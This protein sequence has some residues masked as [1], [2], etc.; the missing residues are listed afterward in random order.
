MSNVVKWLTKAV[1]LKWVLDY[2]TTDVYYSFIHHSSGFSF[3]M[4]LHD[5]YR[6]ELAGSALWISSQQAMSIKGNV[7]IVMTI[8]AVSKLARLLNYPLERLPPDFSY[9]IEINKIKKSSLLKTQHLFQL[10]SMRV[11][12][13]WIKSQS[14]LFKRQIYLLYNVTFL[15]VLLFTKSLRKA[16]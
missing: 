3:C 16:D 5:Q 9:F 2:L 8:M 13:N 4:N 11:A 14:R 10:S 12:G 1:Q 7:T 6:S 15:F